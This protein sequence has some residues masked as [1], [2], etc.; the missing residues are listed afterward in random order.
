MLLFTDTEVVS[1][2][3]DLLY[4]DNTEV[5]FAPWH[6][7]RQEPSGYLP[8]DLYSF[9]IFL[10]S[11]EAPEFHTYLIYRE[12][13]TIN[14]AWHHLY[15]DTSEWVEMDLSVKIFNDDFDW[16]SG[17]SYDSIF[18]DYFSYIRPATTVTLLVSD[19]FEWNAE[20]LGWN[21]LSTDNMETDFSPYLYRPTENGYL[22]TDIWVSLL[23]ETYEVFS[24]VEWDSTPVY[25]DNFNVTPW[26]FSNTVYYHDTY[27][28]LPLLQYGLTFTYIF[29][30]V[31]WSDV[32]YSET[33]EWVDKLNYF[34]PFEEDFEWAP[35][36]PIYMES[37]EL[38]DDFELNKVWVCFLTDS[39]ES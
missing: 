9:R 26:T 18:I 1:P 31:I 6:P 7:V 32:T 35:P 8:H 39:F 10:D 5:D 13:T 38:A 27:E 16:D 34:D 29:E 19:S 14:P 37:P 24:V 2:Q 28:N 21:L 15:S 3:W 17:V 30:L 25:A 11:Y 20:F 36:T 4:L 33:W 12:D 23:R 22:P